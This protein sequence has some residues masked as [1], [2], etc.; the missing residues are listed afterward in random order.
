MIYTPYGVILWRVAIL[1]YELKNPRSSE[2]GFFI[3]VRRTQHHLTEGQHHFERNENIIPHLC[4]HKRMMLRQLANDVM[5]LIND[6]AL[7]TN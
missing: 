2:R 7:R 6:I 1:Y 3:C 5:L 4:G